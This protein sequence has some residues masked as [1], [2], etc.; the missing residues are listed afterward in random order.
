M[1][2]FRTNPNYPD[3]E[4]GDQGTIRMIENLR[5]RPAH[6]SS[7]GRYLVVRCRDAAGELK[8]N[9][10][11]RFI[12]E[13]YH[14]NPDNRKC[15]DH[16]NGD[17]TDNRA[18]NLRWCT[19]AQNTWNSKVSTRNT[20]G[21]KGV[22]WSKAGKSWHAHITINN[23]FRSIGYYKDKRDAV[24]ARRAVA[25]NLMGEFVAAN[26]RGTLLL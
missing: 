18:S 3:C 25:H 11:H 19:A 26:E 22:S 17:N 24:G 21:F 15:I 23:L 4:F 7:Q 10:V 5:A 16:I 9:Y 6:H 14:P 8:R 2:A 12:C 20:S 1:E 13:T